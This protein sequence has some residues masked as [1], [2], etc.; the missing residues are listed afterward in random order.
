MGMKAIREIKNLPS[1]TSADRLLRAESF[2]ILVKKIN[3][4]REMIYEALS[5]LTRDTDCRVTEMAQNA[6][7]EINSIVEWSYD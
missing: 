4:Q 7:R 6:L 1:R 2:A 3:E 5:P